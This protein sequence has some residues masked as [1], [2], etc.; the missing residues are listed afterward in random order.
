MTKRVSSV[1]LVG[2]RKLPTTKS[3]DIK[4]L[5]LD[6][7]VFV[8]GAPR[9]GT[10]ILHALICTSP[11]TNDY[12]AEC[13]Y[14][15]DMIM[16]YLLGLERWE[17]HTK[18]FFGSREDLFDYH[19]RI[20]LDVVSRIHD[21][22]GNP[23]RLTLK[24]PIMAR[25]FHHVAQLLPQARFVVIYRD[26]RDAILSR[27]NVTRR[28][29]HGRKPSKL[30]IKSACNEYNISYEGIIAHPHI[31]NARM[32]VLNYNDINKGAWLP[33]LERFGLHGI[34][35]QKIWSSSRTQIT[36][37]QSNPWSTEL[38]GTALSSLSVNRHESELDQ[39][40]A[41]FIMEQCGWVGKAFGY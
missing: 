16:P 25:F 28:L 9:T 22:L 33:D 21:Q 3:E 13:S 11:N 27:L 26:P 30:D 23:A 34:D 10:T 5:P 41:D 24:D 12:I 38:Y 31:L 32:I 36:E 4:R 14:L 15:T 35:P 37:Y 29:K 17:I 1:G 6:D 18:H 19:S 40:T 7:L 8:G 39:K 20:V 2:H